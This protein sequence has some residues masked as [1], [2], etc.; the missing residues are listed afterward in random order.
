MPLFGLINSEQLAATRNNNARRRVFYDY[1]TGKFPLTGLLS[2]MDDAEPLSDPTLAW[3][4]ESWRSARAKTAVGTTTSLGCMVTSLTNLAQAGNATKAIGATSFIRVSSADD[5]RVRDV[6]RVANATLVNAS[7][8]SFSAIVINVDRVNRTLEIQHIDAQLAA[9]GLENQSTVNLSLNIS[10]VGTAAGEGANARNDGTSNQPIRVENHTQI[11][12]TV[13]GPWTGSALKMGQIWD[14][15]PVYKKD[16]KDASLR[17]MVALEKSIILGEKRITTETLS[18]GATVPVRI[19]GGIQYYLRQWD[20]GTT[21]NGGEFNYRPGGADLTNLPFTSSDAEEKRYITGVGQITK[22][23]WQELLRRAFY[24]CSD[25]GSEKLAVCGDKILAV[26]TDY[27]D[28]NSIRTETLDAKSESYGMKITRLSTPH[29]DLL[30]KTHPLFKEDP[31]LQN[32]MAILDMGDMAYH[33][34]DGRDTELLKNRQ[35]N[36]EDLRLD[37]FLTECTLEFRKPRRHMF[38]EGLTGILT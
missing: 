12:R 32:A 19:S 2:L 9:S 31:M 18:S 4:E 17:H 28:R 34:L 37:E 25:K 23:Q 35:G 26:I 10:V 6:V 13:C 1:P 3:Y 15:K 16:V 30:F 29:G 20:K 38:I 24:D 8:V 5:F 36:G 27:C 21:A 11:H 33:C 22:S 7:V 14:S